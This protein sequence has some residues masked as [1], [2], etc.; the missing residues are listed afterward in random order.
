MSD[1]RTDLSPLVSGL[2]AFPDFVVVRDGSRACVGVEP[3]ELVRVSGPGS[4]DALDALT[5]GWWA[6]FLAFDL[7]RS[8]ER[9][10]GLAT[11]DL[12]LPD[13]LL[14]RFDA[15]AE[16]DLVEGSA[17]V[18]G[19]GA[20]ARRLRRLLD[21]GARA[22]A[23]IPVGPGAV[24]LGSP[25]SSLDR[26]AYTARVAR[27][28]EHIR[29]GDCYQVNLTRRLSW[30]RRA[31]PVALFASLGERNPA[32]H[33][34]LL[35][36]D[37]VAVISASPERFLRWCGGGGVETRPVKGTSA[38]A[39]ALRASAKDRAENVM[40][41]DLARNDLGRVCEPGSIHVPSL[42]ALEAHPGL[43]HLVSTVRGHRRANTTLGDLLRAT[44]PP[45]SVT[46]A[47]KPRVLEIIEELE[48]VR[49][50]V[51]CG[52][53]GWLDTSRDTGDL[54]VAIRTF[55]TTAAGTSLGVGAGI[56]ADSDPVAEWQETELKAARLLAAA[57][58]VPAP[59]FAGVPR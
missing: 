4:F 34:T 10:P 27:V 43:H 53:I 58:A 8:V 41:V 9:V 22:G 21:G 38:D 55:T 3:V 23:P 24:E 16:L 50:G 59:Q 12:G 11:D 36:L 47:P 25:T 6:G 29:A 51:Y 39:A 56:V 20:A 18:V 5:P 19:R 2:S 31:D 37:G 44:M 42:C 26:H 48:P 28:I 57:G 45:A 54:A 52:A 46:G 40:I 1:P 49:R 33:A 15:R 35:K 17:S 30:P 14:A 7:G 13:V 32:P